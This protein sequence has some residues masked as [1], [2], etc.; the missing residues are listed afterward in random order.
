MFHGFVRDP[1]GS[2]TTFDAPGAGTG[3]NQGTLAWDINP[4]GATAGI[5]MD[6]NNVTH[7]FVRSR[8]NEITSFDPPGSVYTYPCEETCLSPDGT[9]TGFYFDANNVIHGFVRGPDGKITEFERLEREPAPTR[10]PSCEHQPGEG[11]ITGYFVDSNNVAHGFVRTRDG[12]FT[13]FDVPGARAGKAPPLFRS[14]CSGRSPG[15]SST[16]TMRCTASPVQPA[17]F[18]PHSTRPTRARAPSK[19]RAPRPTTR[20]GPSPAG[21]LTRTT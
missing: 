6:G 7:G 12:N 2:F 10:A 21:T 9:I 15:S 8:R 3:T 19:V 1:D 20:K 16:Q 13:T 17:A 5:Y 14:I 11:T 4:E 18:S